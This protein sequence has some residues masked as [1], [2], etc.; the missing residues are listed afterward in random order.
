[1]KEHFISFKTTLDKSLVMK[2]NNDRCVSRK[3][4]DPNTDRDPSTL[5]VSSNLA[6]KTS[7]LLWCAKAKHRNALGCLSGV[8][9]KSYHG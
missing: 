7:L 9:F 5:L 2:S 6:K 4:L 8:P 3:F 1:M